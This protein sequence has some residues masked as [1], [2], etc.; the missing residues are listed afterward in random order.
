[1]HAMNGASTL[2]D[3]AGKLIAAYRAGEFGESPVAAPLLRQF[4][5][6][7]V[8]LP[9]IE[10]FKKQV[11]ALVRSDAREAIQV[12]E[13]AKSLSLLSPDAVARALGARMKAMA[14][15]VSSRYAEAVE[16][17]RQATDI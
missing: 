8:D 11:D 6:A 4:G 7:E 13:L 12:A 2:Q 16:N 14:L 9:L 5:V 3:V 15:H 1:M 10:Q 17:Y